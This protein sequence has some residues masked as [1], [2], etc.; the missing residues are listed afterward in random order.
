MTISGAALG[1]SQSL[2]ARGVGEA[3]VCSYMFGGCS[4]FVSQDSCHTRQT[5]AQKRAISP[6]RGRPG[7]RETGVRQRAA[8]EADAGGGRQA[9][10][11]KGMDGVLKKEGE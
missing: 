8:L 5:E 11:H 4:G 1:M 7:A 6:H 3:K 9:G 2:T 10:R